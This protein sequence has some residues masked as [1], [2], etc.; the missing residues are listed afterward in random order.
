MSRVR[1]AVSPVFDFRDEVPMVEREDP[2]EHVLLN[3]RTVLLMGLAL[4]VASTGEVGVYA[5]GELGGGP[6]PGPLKEW[7]GFL[8]V[9]LAMGVGALLLMVTVQDAPALAEWARARKD[10]MLLRRGLRGVLGVLEGYSKAREVLRGQLAG[11]TE[12]TEEAAQD[13]VSRFQKLDNLVGGMTARIQAGMEQIEALA[14]QVRENRARDRQVLRS[15]QEYLTGRQKEMER[16]WQRVEE[17]LAEAEQ[18]GEFTAMVKDIADQ[19]N[20]LALNAAIEAA[21]VGQ[22]G[23]GFAVVAAEIRSLSQRSAEAAQRIEKGFAEMT[24]SIRAKFAQQLDSAARK[25]QIATLEEVGAAL[26]AVG[27]ASSEVPVVVRAVLEETRRANEEVSR[28]VMEGLASIQFQDITR[29]RLEHV[30]EVLT[31]MD[32]HSRLL[33]ERG[34]GG[35]LGSVPPFDVDGMSSGYTMRGQRAIHEQTKGVAQVPLEEEGP[36]IELF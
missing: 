23:K 19:T 2:R 6:L 30:A 34:Q 33:R 21:R 27:A 10:L 32:R 26:G 36:R 17:M 14:A 35:D 11:V 22:A 13:I 16:E 31:E 28:E 24:E 18:L 1:S 15:M 20:L 5:W 4:V 9:V 3:R 29:Q 7:T 12:V 8:S 25:G